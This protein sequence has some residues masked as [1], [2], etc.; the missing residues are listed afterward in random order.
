MTNIK[1]QLLIALT[2]CL[3]SCSVFNKKNEKRIFQTKVLAL[4]S[5][6]SPQFKNCAQKSDLFTLMKSERLRVVMLLSIAP[7]SQINSFRLDKNS[8]PP[9]FSDCLF[10]I[11]DLLV[12]PENK[13]GKLIELE[14]PFIFSNK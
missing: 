9:Q 4:L 13:L 12:L 1:L 5:K 8:Y 7:N 6:S 11:V 3:S 2:L 10:D 14:Q